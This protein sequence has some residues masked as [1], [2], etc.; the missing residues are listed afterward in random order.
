MSILGPEN[1]VSVQDHLLQDNP[2]NMR[3]FN[4]IK[5]NIVKAIS[6]NKI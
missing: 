2:N 4:K 1:K 5:H 3:L 6:L